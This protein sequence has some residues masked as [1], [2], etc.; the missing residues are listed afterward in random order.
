MNAGMNNKE[1]LNPEA[2]RGHRSQR[3]PLGIS[4]I[5][6]AYA[7]L[8][9]VQGLFSVGRLA[10]SHAAR[11]EMRTALEKLGMQMPREQFESLLAVMIIAQGLFSLAYLVLGTGLLKKQGW[12]RSILLYFILA[13]A[14]IALAV[15]VI[16]PQLAFYLILFLLYP[17]A[18]FW[19][20]TKPETRAWFQRT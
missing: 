8:F 17:A 9:G 18:V 1:P 15:S 19:Y 2:Q 13:S 5:G 16:Q 14:V 4:I 12:A 20:L 11:E 6:Y 10:V 3:R 7:L